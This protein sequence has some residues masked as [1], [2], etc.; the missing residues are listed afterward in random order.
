MLVSSTMELLARR[1][2]SDGYAIRALA[3]A[4]FDACE[5]N[6][7]GR[8]AGEG[9]FAAEMDA[10]DAYFV[11]LKGA[12]RDCGIEVWQTQM[13]FATRDGA[14]WLAAMRRAVRAT[15]LLGSRYLAYDPRPL[16]EGKGAADAKAAVTA[17]CGA[18]LPALREHGIRLALENTA[19]PGL[20][21]EALVAVLEALGPDHFCACL[22]TGRA[23]LAGKNPSAM[24]KDLG[25]WLK[26]IRVYDWDERS[27]EPMPPY[28]GGADWDEI[29][30]VLSRSEYPGTL[31]LYTDA[32]VAKYPEVMEGSVL[33]LLSDTGEHLAE[34]VMME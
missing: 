28:L 22:D 9:L 19:S 2:N 6:L 11:E 26:I 18:L 30:K 17:A 16:L 8:P 15:A 27:G 1:H 20:P 24:I 12:A 29:C 21:L 13:P 25:S 10:F 5:Y 31:N 14:A 34:K 4:G 33:R 7:C 32:F 23:L 3:R